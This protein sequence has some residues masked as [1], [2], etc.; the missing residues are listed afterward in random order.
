MKK[1]TLWLGSF[2][3][4]LAFNLN[5][6]T[7][8]FENT[9]VGDIPNGWVKYQSQA[10][11]PGFE[12]KDDAGY[13]YEGSH[14][15]VHEG[16]DIAA[17]STSWV[18]SNAIYVGMDYEI[19]FLWRG[20]WSNAYNFTAAYIS[21]GSNDPVANPGDFTLLEEYSPA[22]FPDTWLQW[23]DMRYGLNQYNGQTVYLAFKYVGDHAHD[24]F[25]DN[26]KIGPMPYC[27]APTNLSVTDRTMDSINVL[28]EASTA[29]E[30]EVVWGAPGFDPNNATNSAIVNDITY[31]ITG[32]TTSTTYDIYVRS[33]CS[34]Y[35]HSTWEGPVT[36][37]TS[38]PPPTNND[39]V[40]AENLTVYPSGNGAGNET[41]GDTTNA[42]DSGM[43]PTC[44]GTGPN[45]D[46]WY[47]FTLPANSGGVKVI[48]D[49]PGGNN[50][51]AA[52][53]EN[54]GGAELVCKDS[55][56]PMIISGLSGGNTYILQTW[57]DAADADAF[58]IVLEEI[59]PAPVNDECAD[60]VNLDIYAPGDS[61]GHE[62]H[63][64]L[65]SATDSGSHPTCD[66]IGTNLD[67]W[68]SFRL[69]LGENGI[70]V[71][72]SG[73]LGNNIEAA[74]YD[75]CGGTEIACEGQ[76][77][78]KIFTG[79]TPGTVYVL[80]TWV[81]D[82]YVGDF[83][84]A[85]ETILPPPTNIDCAN[86]QSMTVYPF[87][88]TAG[89]EL[90]QTT[91]GVTDSGVH[92][93]CDDT[94]TN[95]DLWYTVTVPIN[96]N[97]FAI[98]TSGDKG[99]E[100]EAAVYNNCGGTEIDCFS[101]GNYKIVTGLSGG[102][103]YYVQVW[104][105]D[106]NSGDFN[107]VFESM[108]PPPT[109]DTCNN[110]IA[111]QPSTT[112]SNPT[113][114]RNLGASDSGVPDPGCGSYQGGDIW[115]SVTIPSSGNL[116]IETTRVANSSVSDTGMAVYEGSCNGLN[117]IE[118]D[119][120]DSADGL[121]SLVSLTGRTPGE[122]IY[123]RVWEYGNNSFGEIGVCAYDSS[124]SISENSI[125]GLQ[126]YPNPVTDL[127]T[128]RA[129]K[130]LDKIVIYNMIGQEVIVVNNNKTNAQIDMSHLQKGVYFVKV[131]ADKTLTAFKVVKQ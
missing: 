127:I 25:I 38:G 2:L 59:P 4:L 47:S 36:G 50:L 112:C 57:H 128:I 102:Q 61:T 97:G 116:T 129:D 106:F 103:T 63:T 111:I 19:T 40:N 65:T 92:P 113:I 9:P 26:V 79:L 126:F 30:Y 88:N 21:T 70:K 118:C 49:G 72:T 53:Y 119:D 27:E 81:D 44:D 114:G 123:I 33:A 11:D 74:L 37:S 77:A 117:L 66:D 51:K 13:A 18:V 68:F 96:D 48:I 15:L 3:L 87:G 1:I 125:E 73:T 31:Q 99:N 109:N 95:L 43:H 10:D 54:C 55:G 131:S 80:Q 62:I 110:A 7:E 39:C 16:V 124:V 69:P 34:S 22:N 14:Y 17:E 115:F 90:A 76:S 130:V 89:N 52:I 35:N 8:G 121:F 56:S 6:Q 93:S 107:I 104:L 28:W 12:V 20:R 45:Y 32:L 41:N 60:A 24:F 100:I 105:D 23:N 46:I 94:G 5:A 85:L 84:I 122:T 91:I 42:S 108:A 98:A 29:T 78:S 82:I 71:L 83:D 64:D 101:N 75:A 120:D 67:V 58:T 86:A